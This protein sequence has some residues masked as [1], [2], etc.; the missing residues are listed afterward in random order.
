MI[1]YSIIRGFQNPVSSPTQYA[2]MYSITPTPRWSAYI[3]D[4]LQ[5]GHKD[6]SKPMQR[7]CIIETKVA[8]YTLIENQLYHRCKDGNL[9]LCVPK[10]QCL[11]ILYHVHASIA[12]GHFLGPKT[13]RNILWTGLWWPTLQQDAVEFVKHCEHCQRTKPPVVNDKMTL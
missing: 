2:T 11:E 8:N 3:E 5:T 1:N 6:Q 12:R 9:Q 4:Y 10:S 13:A 7:R